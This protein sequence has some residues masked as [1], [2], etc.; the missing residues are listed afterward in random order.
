[1]GTFLLFQHHSKMSQQ[2]KTKSGLTINPIG[3]IQDLLSG[4]T[5]QEDRV[6]Q[7]HLQS[8]GDAF[9]EIGKTEEGQVM[10]VAMEGLAAR[11]HTESSFKDAVKVCFRLAK[12]ITKN[13]W[14]QFGMF[15]GLFGLLV[16]LIGQF[17][18]MTVF[19][20]GLTVLMRR[21]GWFFISTALMP[22]SHGIKESVNMLM[23]TTEEAVEKKLDAEMIDPTFE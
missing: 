4:T 7:G 15:I 11:I 23:E 20:G 3:S 8:L 1:M 9:H 17:G 2:I 19:G 21:V 10:L 14:V 13:P 12:K 6:A 22:I 18:T 5:F 16:A